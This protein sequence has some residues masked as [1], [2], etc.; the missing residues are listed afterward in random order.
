MKLRATARQTHEN[1]FHPRLAQPPSRTGQRAIFADIAAGPKGV[2]SNCSIKL[3][4]N[5]MK[6]RKF[7][8]LL[9]GS[10][11]TVEGGGK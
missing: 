10:S 4:R 5:E 2:S 3:R 11:V 8:T 6:N 7:N 9:D 1:T